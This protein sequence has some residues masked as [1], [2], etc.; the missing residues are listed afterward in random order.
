MEKKTEQARELPRFPKEKLLTFGRFSGRRDLLGALLKD[1][2]EYTL[3]EAE[4]AIRG[5]MK[6]A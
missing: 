5:F 6:G 1:G 3:D 4:A 2:G